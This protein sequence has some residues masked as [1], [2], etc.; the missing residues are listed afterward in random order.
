MAGKQISRMHPGTMAQSDG[1]A[2]MLHPP[3]VSQTRVVLE[4]YSAAG[5]ANQEV[6]IENAGHVPYL[7]NLAEF[8]RVLHAHLSR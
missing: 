4:A 8:D 7:D 3:R 6:V 2:I 1:S 5:G